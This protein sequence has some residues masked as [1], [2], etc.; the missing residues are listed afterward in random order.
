MGAFEQ[1]FAPTVEALDDITLDVPAAYAILG[2]LLRASGLPREAVYR[3]A[4]TINV[5]EQVLV[6]PRDKLMRAFD[7]A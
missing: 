2:R 7:D 6:H 5:Y 1:G 3:L 4:G